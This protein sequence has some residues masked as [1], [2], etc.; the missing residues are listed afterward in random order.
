MNLVNALMEDEASASTQSK[1]GRNCP[2]CC[3]QGK[4]T[5]ESAHK[6]AK[7]GTPVQLFG[8][9]TLN[10]DGEEGH[11]GSDR[12][13]WSC[14]DKG[15]PTVCPNNDTSSSSHVNFNVTSETEQMNLEQGDADEGYICFGC[16]TQRKRCVSTKPLSLGRVFYICSNPL[17][18]K[19]RQFLW[20]RAKAQPNKSVSPDKINGT[21]QKSSNVI[22][23]YFLQE[24]KCAVC[25]CAIRKAMKSA[26]C[27]NCWKQVHFETCSPRHVTS[28]TIEDSTSAERLCHNCFCL[29]CRS[30]RKEGHQ[31]VCCVC[32]LIVDPQVNSLC[33]RCEKLVHVENCSKKIRAVE[34]ENQQRFICMQCFAA[35]VSGVSTAM[36][37]EIQSRKMLSDEHMTRASDILS[38]QFSSKIDGLCAPLAVSYGNSVDSSNYCITPHEQQDYVQIM[39]TGRKHWVT[40]IFPERCQKV[41][42][43]D[44]CRTLALSGHTKIQVAMIAREK[45]TTITVNR[46]ACKQ[47]NNAYDCGLFAIANAVEYCFASSTDFVD[48]NPSAMRDHL[49]KCFDA[50]SFTQFPRLNS[51]RMKKLKEDE[52][53]DTFDI[54]CSCRL[55][56]NFDVEMVV[57]DQCNEWFHV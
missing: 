39:N 27:S 56:N 3:E 14:Y 18:S 11:G 57:C 4:P 50:G 25:T 51:S 1:G 45:G 8:C 54:S 28:D 33:Y 22:Q 38:A 23:N 15:Q 29:L 13:C 6:C 19:C 37:S 35:M 5:S 41:V 34:K 48:F 32:T 24:P 52:I 43:L 53:T 12:I 30:I 20:A 36:R 21:P 26:V 46:P 47:Q 55:P 40:A 9:S 31:C 10:L 7:C 42:V 16:Q 2:I 49:L 44:S 17:N